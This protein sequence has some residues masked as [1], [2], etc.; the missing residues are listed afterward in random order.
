MSLGIFLGWHITAAPFLLSEHMERTAYPTEYLPTWD[1]QLCH[2]YIP[3]CPEFLMVCSLIL[4]L[5]WK[6]LSLKIGGS[7][8]TE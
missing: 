8:C 5:V 1:D 3:F 6:Q 4:D 2:Y 7:M